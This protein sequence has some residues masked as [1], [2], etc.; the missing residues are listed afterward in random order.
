[1][2]AVRA[3]GS[4]ED[5]Q[6]QLELSKAQQ[7]PREWTIYL[8]PA[9]GERRSDA[10]NRLYRRLLRKMAQQ[11]GRSVKYWNEF[12]VERFLGLD[13][14]ETEDGCVLKVLCS[15]SELSVAEFTEFLNACLSF[16]ADHQVH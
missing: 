1:M 3:Y 9:R 15:T 6:V 16:A 4:L 14:V 2:T 8:I 7:S 13:E 12:L 5:N 11:L 10:Q